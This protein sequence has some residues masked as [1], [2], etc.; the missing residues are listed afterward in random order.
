MAFY[1]IAFD[2]YTIN[3]TAGKA[4]QS[5]ESGADIVCFN[6]NNFIGLLRFFSDSTIIPD[7]QRLSDGTIYLYYEMSR[8]NDVMTLIR[9]E[10]P[11][12]LAINADT[13]YGY[14]GCGQLEPVGEQEGV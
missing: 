14:I 9:Y 12:F 2:R 10:K 7:N 3:Y 6:G 11:L 13:K 5:K 4:L 1:W 8:F